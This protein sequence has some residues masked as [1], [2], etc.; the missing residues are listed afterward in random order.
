MCQLDYIDKFSSSSLKMNMIR[1]PTLEKC[2]HF[3][4]KPCSKAVQ[5]KAGT[6]DY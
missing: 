2:G 3:H 5:H 6:G 4:L 1:T